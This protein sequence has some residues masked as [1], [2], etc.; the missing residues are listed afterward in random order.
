MTQCDR[1]KDTKE[2]QSIL[3]NE[4]LFLFSLSSCDTLSSSCFGFPNCLKGSRTVGWP[5]F[6]FTAR[7]RIVLRGTA[8][9][10]TFNSSLSTGNG[11]QQSSSSSRLRNL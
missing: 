10:N 5:E 1:R 6:G 11:R 2:V 4:D 8:T 9:T 3:H 7:S